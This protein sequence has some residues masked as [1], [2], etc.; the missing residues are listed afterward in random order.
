MK[1]WTWIFQK[2]WIKK[3]HIC[4]LVVTEGAPLVHSVHGPDIEGINP[5][6]IKK[7][8]ATE[9]APKDRNVTKSRAFLPRIKGYGKL[10]SCLSGLV[11]PD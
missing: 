6:E 11:K 9:L 8:E 7:T 1:A 10:I 5:G 3:L 2:Q 4:V